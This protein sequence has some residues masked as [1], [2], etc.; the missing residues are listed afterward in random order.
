MQ[1]DRVGE[2]VTPTKTKHLTLPL[3]KERV[4]KQPANE[5][6]HVNL[7]QKMRH[8]KAHGKTRDGKRL[9]TDPF[10]EDETRGDIWVFW[11]RRQLTT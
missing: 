2:G 8:P 4:N 5:E 3:W 6:N 7:A 11:S 1:G 9:L 10:T